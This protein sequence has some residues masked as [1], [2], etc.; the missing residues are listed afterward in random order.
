MVFGLVISSLLALGGAVAVVESAWF[1][2][3]ARRRIRNIRGELG[4][5]TL[6]WLRFRQL[7]LGALFFCGV[8][9]AIFTT[10]QIAR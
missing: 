8:I 10:L 4:D 3:N 9:G 6:S 7:S 1:W 5:N 2:E